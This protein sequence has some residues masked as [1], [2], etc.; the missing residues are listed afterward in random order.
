MNKVMITYQNGYPSCLAAAL[1]EFGHTPTGNICWDQA[2]LATVKARKEAQAY[3]MSRFNAIITKA[4]AA[5]EKTRQV[6]VQLEHDDTFRAHQ[7][8]LLWVA[9]EIVLKPQRRKFIID[10]DNRKVL[11]FLLYYFNGC[12]L[13]EDV[14]PDRHYKMHKPLL[15]QGGVGVGKTLLMQIFSEYLRRIGSPNFFHNLSVTQMVNY[16]TIHNNLDRYTYYEEESRG[17]QCQP[18]NVC[19][20]DVGVNDDKKFYGMSVG[21]LTDE[22]LH[23]RNE[24]WTHYQK[25]AHLT[26]NLDDKALRKRFQQNDGYG[27]LVDRFKTYNIIPLGG[28][29]RR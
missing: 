10:D 11:R 19:L 23:A 21:L 15:I 16:Y 27:R 2:V 28:S 1:E 22:F 6:S 7:Q 14:F 29:S 25:C 5:M 4:T 3:D 24:I 8:F 13:C 9:N 26:T 17:F 20:N 18:V 12:P